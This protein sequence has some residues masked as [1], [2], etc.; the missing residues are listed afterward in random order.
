LVIPKGDAAEDW[1]QMGDCGSGRHVPENINQGR[2]QSPRHFQAG[3]FA[4][5]ATNS[6]AC[7]T[8]ARD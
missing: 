8:Y 5:F 4:I 2:E 7:S 3:D 6:L 1:G